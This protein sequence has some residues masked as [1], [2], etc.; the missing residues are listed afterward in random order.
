MFLKTIQEYRQ[1]LR[2]LHFIPRDLEGIERPIRGNLE[3][4]ISLKSPSDVPS[5]VE[6]SPIQ[7]HSLQDN[8]LA[9]RQEELF[10]HFQYMLS[11]VRTT[12][13]ETFSSYLHF[14]IVKIHN[15]LI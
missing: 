4:Q 13:S 6:S 8:E 3:D 9:L 12:F 15:Y 5:P 2:E 11:I 7:T 10:T 1:K 14:K